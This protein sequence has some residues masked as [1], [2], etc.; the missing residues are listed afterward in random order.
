MKKLTSVK[1]SFIL[2]SIV[3]IINFLAYG[4]FRLFGF[5]GVTIF[6]TL[7][8]TAYISV[9]DFIVIFVVSLILFKKK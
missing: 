6:E 2:S 7:A 3:V 5:G 8:F 9:L 1:K 4:S